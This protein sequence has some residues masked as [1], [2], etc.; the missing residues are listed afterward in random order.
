MMR[1]NHFV[2]KVPAQA[3]LASTLDEEVPAGPEMY[4]GVMG[5]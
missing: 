4:W 1:A 3:G 2:S 5:S